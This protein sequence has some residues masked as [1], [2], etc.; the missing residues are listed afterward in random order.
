MKKRIE[1]V[2]LK[3]EDVLR[4]W[5]EHHETKGGK[6]FAYFLISLITLSTVAFVLET[7]S[8]NNQ[9]GWLFRDIEAF[10]VGVF[11]LEYVLRVLVA[12][13]RL[14]FILSPLGLIDLFVILPFFGRFLNLAFL[15][16]FRV[17]RILQVL[18]VIRYSDVMMSFFRSFRYYR[19]EIRI[20]G[21]TFLL[22]LVFS[23]C[24]MYYLEHGINPFFDNIPNALWWAVVTMSTLGY[25]DIVPITIGGK[26]VASLVVLCGLATIAIMTAT[27]TKIFIDHFFGKRLHHCDICHYPYHDHDA[28]YCKNCGQE[29]DKERLE[30]AEVVGHRHHQA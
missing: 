6:I 15:R 16:G 5:L 3:V 30:H 7:T 19:D 24:S 12:R 17:L 13:D 11:T 8:L 4:D 20:F 2:L 27:I 28:K 9:W 22:V 29:L 10:V 1:K 21:M 23:A 18:K 14:R 26:I 25:G